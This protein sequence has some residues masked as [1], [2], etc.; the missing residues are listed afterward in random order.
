MVWVVVE[1]LFSIL[2]II[3]YVYY[4]VKVWSLSYNLPNSLCVLIN[5]LLTILSLI[6]IKK[7]ESERKNNEGAS[8]TTTK[9]KINT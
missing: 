1:E 7:I 4:G 8:K 3:F 6:I 5:L 2:V 9:T